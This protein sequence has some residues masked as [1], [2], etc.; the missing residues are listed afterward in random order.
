MVLELELEDVVLVDL[1]AWAWS[2][3]AV[4]KQGQA[5]QWEVIWKRRKL[6][7]ETTSKIFLCSADG[8]IEKLGVCKK[9]LIIRFGWIQKDLEK[10]IFIVRIVWC[11]NSHF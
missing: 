2:V 11:R 10:E 7:K 8:L 1:V 5:C 6:L 3:H 9:Y 4:T